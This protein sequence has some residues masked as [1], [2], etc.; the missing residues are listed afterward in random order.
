MELL[1]RT[2]QRMEQQQ[3]DIDFVVHNVRRD[4]CEY[5]ITGKA[6]ET[7]KQVVENIFWYWRFRFYID[8]EYRYLL[9]FLFFH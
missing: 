4:I 6:G 8:D 9:C 2:G 3:S 5:R 7:L 1:W